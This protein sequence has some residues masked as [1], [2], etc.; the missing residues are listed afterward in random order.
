M[1]PNLQDL[2]L[3]HT[4]VRPTIL[5]LLADQCPRLEIIRWN[6]NDNY[7]ID[8]DGDQLQSMNNLKELYLDNWYFGFDPENLIYREEG[9]DDNGDVDGDVDGDDDGDDDNGVT[10]IEAMADCNNY[11]NLFLFHKVC[12]NPLERISLRNAR[13]THFDLDEGTVPQQ[14]LMKFVRKAPSTLLWFRS[15]LSPE[16][17]RIL[18]SERPGIQFLN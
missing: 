10:E 1:V 11:P 12:N 16:N 8:A 13:Y 5:Q 2:D 6:D 17:V 4:R 18:Q 14:I 3:S 7:A 15:D 9:T